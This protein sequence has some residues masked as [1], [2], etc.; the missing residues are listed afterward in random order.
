MVPIINL[1]ISESWGNKSLKKKTYYLM[2]EIKSRVSHMLG[3]T[4]RAK[5]SSIIEVKSQVGP[6]GSK[7]KNRCRV[8][9]EVK[10]V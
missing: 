10:V 5:P 3:S 8:S 4:I 9:I 6:R 7:E 2:L 1:S